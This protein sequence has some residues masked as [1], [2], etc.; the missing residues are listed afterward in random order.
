M[1]L[2]IVDDDALI[3]ESLSLTL[4]LEDDIE[5]IGEA[6]NGRD[7]LQLCKALSPDIILM[8]IRM[9]GVDGISATQLIKD[10]HPGV[11]IMMLTTFADKV[12]IQNALSAGADGYLLKTDETAT[13][14]VKLRTL[15]SGGGVIDAD[16]LKHLTQPVNPLMNSLSTRERDITRLVAQGLTNKEIAAQLFLSE[17]TVRNKILMIMDK[18]S[19][20]NRTQLGVAYYDM[21]GT[22]S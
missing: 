5:I 14:A 21:T 1:R 13:I 18:V 9:P 8:D 15:I 20:K 10:K 4:S 16:V 19:V 12:N 3:R 17:G 7:A 6:E 2:L 11:K 22:I